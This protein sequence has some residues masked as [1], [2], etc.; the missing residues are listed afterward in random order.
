[1]PIR[2]RL[3]L[4]FA[5]IL[6]IILVFSGV[7]LNIILQSYLYNAIDSDLKAY[8]A[9]VHGSL[10]PNST[11]GP[12]DYSMIHSSL[13]SV[14]EFSS[15]AIYVQLINANG[16]VVV[17]SDNLSNQELPVNPL[18][19][20]KAIGGH[21]DIQNV[22]SGGNSSVRIMVS[23]LYMT[24]QTLILEVA[25]STR[26]VDAALQQFRLA[27]I[28]GT[29]TA[30]VL[31]GLL[32]AILVRR[33]LEPVKRITRTARSIEESS[34]LNRRVD[35]KGPKDEIGQLANTF[36]DM[37]ERL[38]KAFESQKHFIADA[39]HELRTPL[40][41]I[42]G[43]LDLLKRNMSEEDRRE[44]LRAIESET[45]RMTKIAGDLLLLADIESGQALKLETVSLKELVAEEIRRAQLLAGNR[46]VVAGRVESLSVKG[47][48]YKLNQVL[49]NLVD[50]AIKYTPD[51]G[52]I[53][54]SAFR[55]GD[56]AHL[57]V[58][59]TGIGIA[60]ENLPNLF[61]RFY[62]VD[63]ARSRAKGG[64]GL[65]LAIV[66]GIVEQHGGK[67]TVASEQGQGSTFTVWL[68]L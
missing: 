63:K 24:D 62:R 29:L 30:L 46:K 18:L 65:G 66:K 61:D 33:T 37:I 26:P 50:N 9:R 23:P 25:Q 2:W 27:L 17:K 20:E 59:D 45:R 43:N 1:M 4:W 58:A 57:E 47:D 36:D 39:S 8:S 16:R 14:N 41:V 6:L 13:P 12:L 5:L 60:A 22:A 53:T 40:T 56:W 44:S 21:T 67:V 54:L 7:V 35:Y 51:T 42:Q 11:S 49:S 52:T 19:I 28:G 38:D 3:T 48:S 55:D 31:T 10:N 32:G 64:T 15:P 68:K 34:N